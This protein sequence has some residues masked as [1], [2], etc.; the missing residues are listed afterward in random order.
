MYCTRCGAD[1]P[2]GANFCAR[3]GHR[4]QEERSSTSRLAPEQMDAPE[5]EVVARAAGIEPPE[6]DPGQALLV[7]VRGPNEGARFLLDRDMVSC[8]RH[9]DSDIFLD[10]VTVSR[11]HATFH[12]TDGAFSVHDDDSLNGTYVNGERVDAQTLVTG[13]EVQIGR[14]KLVAF[15]AATEP[16]R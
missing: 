4:L 6:V 10:D 5:S 2:D 16:T 12:R 11:R 9:P 8:G 14:F 3:C 15:V 13:D 1:N 7:V